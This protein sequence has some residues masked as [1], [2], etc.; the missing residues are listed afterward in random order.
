VQGVVIFLVALAIRLVH[1]WQIRR[2]PFFD[3]LMGDAHGYDD[4]AR[5]I[6]A[7]DWIGHDVFYQAPL[8]PY[9]LGALYRVFGH[10]LLIVRVCQAIVGSSACVLLGL[11]GRRLFAPIV[12]LVA[13][14][15]LAIYAPAIFFDGLI[16]KSV[17]DVFF[18]CLS[19]WLLSGLVAQPDKR[20]AWLWLGLAMGGLSLTRENALVLVA[21]ILSWGVISQVQPTSAGSLARRTFAPVGLFVLGLALVLLPVATRN[22]ALGGG[23]YLTTSQFG[24]NLY[25]GNRPNADGSYES[26]R[27]GRGAPEYERQD[28]TDLA[29]QARGRSLTPAEVSSY[30]TGRALDFMTSRPGAWLKLMGRKFVLLWNATEMLDT[31]SQET[32]A[33]WSTPLRI[34]GWFG[35]FGILVPLALF[36]VWMTWV[37]RKRL[38]LLYAMTLAYAASVLMFYVFARY[39]FPLVPLLMLFAAAGLVSAPAFVRKGRTRDRIAAL[40]GLAGVAIFTNWPAVSAALNQAVTETNLGAEL[41]AKARFDDAIAH[42]RRAIELEPG[43]APAYNNMGTAFQ[44]K[45]DSTRAVAT[46]EQALSEWPDYPDA[47]YNLANALMSEHKADE[48]AV[49]FDIALKSMPSSVDVRNNLGIALAVQGR[50]DEAFA[51]FKEALKLDPNS[52]KAHR[53]LGDALTSLGRGDDAIAELRR[54]VELDPTDAHAHYD[55]GLALLDRQQLPDAVTELRRTI[56]LTPDSVD[57]HDNLGV[58]LGSLGKFDEAIEQFQQA[59]NIKPDDANARANLAM[60]LRARQQPT[61]TR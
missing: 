43:Y 4:W 31:E 9:F 10:D 55:L 23:F 50:L 6:A 45:G 26:L 34:G 59:V 18:I 24:P 33:E 25:I 16:Q 11:A 49:H 15:A 39:R 14:L 36:G 41:Q 12:G 29:E 7:G 3:L 30:W 51:Q 28:A 17:L 61:G 58:A 40:V 52:A 47:H 2:A 46:Y 60:A 27:Y 32:Y 35:H 48:A 13:G 19:L 38:W 20:I 21:V 8:Y 54:A 22:Y 44:A 57:A 5:Q 42:Y 56:E 37:A 53:N 1:L